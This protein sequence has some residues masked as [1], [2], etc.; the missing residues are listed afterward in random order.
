MKTLNEVIRACELCWKSRFCS[1]P[2]GDCPYEPNN[3]VTDRDMKDDIL[4]YLHEYQNLLECNN[5]KNEIM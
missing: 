3:C 2:D 5:C 4:H 1:D